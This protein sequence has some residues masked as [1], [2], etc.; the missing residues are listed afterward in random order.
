MLLPSCCCW[1]RDA[2]SV[3]PANRCSLWPDFGVI[4]P[5]RKQV[6]Y[7]R[8]ALRAANLG[9][10]RVGN[11]DDY[12]GQEAKVVIIS[13]VRGGLGVEA[14]CVCPPLGVDTVERRS[15]TGI[16]DQPWVCRCSCEAACNA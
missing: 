16:V 7:V 8:Q 10:V 2:A 4:C 1:S 14:L 15:C 9:G 3:T 13:T 11:V 12:Q 5:Y 6:L